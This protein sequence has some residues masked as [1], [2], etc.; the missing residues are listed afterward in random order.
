ME[1]IRECKEFT[2]ASAEGYVLRL[3]LSPIIEYPIQQLHHVQ[4]G[5]FV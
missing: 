3:K 1:A 4:Q 5:P 2:Q